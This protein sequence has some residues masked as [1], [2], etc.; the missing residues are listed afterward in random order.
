MLKRELRTQLEW[1]EILEEELKAKAIQIHAL[2]TVS[3]EFS[4]SPKGVP[5]FT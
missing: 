2:S 1:K 3:T 5:G 4:S